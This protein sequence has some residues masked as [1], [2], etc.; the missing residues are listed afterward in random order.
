MI[1]NQFNFTTKLEIQLEHKIKEYINQVNT[2]NNLMKYIIEWK[3]FINWNQPITIN[4][5][6]VKV[7]LSGKNNWGMNM[8]IT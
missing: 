8:V 7:S 4:C 6:A 3:T 5:K 1:T 2:I